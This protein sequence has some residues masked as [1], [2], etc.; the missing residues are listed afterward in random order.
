MPSPPPISDSTAHAVGQEICR[1]VDFQ[2]TNLG[3]KKR[4]ALDTT[5]GS[6]D[7]RVSLKWEHDL[8]RQRMI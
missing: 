6:S 3:R 7:F 5:I 4:Q 2:I 8:F 1:S